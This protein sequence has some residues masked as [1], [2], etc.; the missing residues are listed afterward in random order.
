M[1]LLRLFSDTHIHIRNANPFECTWT[2]ARCLCSIGE[3]LLVLL[4]SLYKLCLN[5]YLICFFFLYRVWMQTNC[6]HFL[7]YI[8][9]FW[10][11]CVVFAVRFSCFYKTVFVSLFLSQIENMW[12]LEA[13][14][15]QLSW[16]TKR[17]RRMREKNG[18][19]QYGFLIRK[20]NKWIFWIERAY[21]P[22]ATTHKCTKWWWKKS[23]KKQTKYILNFM[24][25][26]ICLL[27]TPTCRT[28]YF[29]STLNDSINNNNSDVWEF[30][31]KKER[32]NGRN[33]HKH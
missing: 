28:Y 7:S 8:L 27:R 1:R 23:N 5:V 30:D 3:L 12:I 32:K 20:Q 15:K 19:K 10:E 16:H 25:V 26:T 6:W 14:E 18:E 4:F 9:Y 22:H 24:C 29:H 17:K 2:I 13:R 31:G 21:T 11:W 33:K